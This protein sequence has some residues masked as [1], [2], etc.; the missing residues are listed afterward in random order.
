MVAIISL[1]LILVTSMILIRVASVALEKTGLSRDSARFQAR[2]AFTG[3]GFTTAEAEHVVAGP[4]R[5]RIIM[6]LMLV[7]NVGIVSAMGATLVSAIDLRTGQGIGSL[8][9]VLVS[10]LALLCVLGSSRWIDQKICSVIGWALNRWTTLDVQD[11][12]LLLHLRDEYG[13]SRFRVKAGDWVSGKTLREARLMEEGLVVLGI[14][15]PEGEFLGTPPVDVEVRIGDE[16]VVYGRAAGVSE[17]EAR[18]HGVPGDLAHEGATA[19]HAQRTK[20]ARAQA[21]R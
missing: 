3:V 17:L 21:G 19:D 11:Y 5:R 2:S 4:V 8:L 7:G 18:L 16:L 1:L 15:C 12:S 20:G 6:W 9:V 14:E 13:V 10:G